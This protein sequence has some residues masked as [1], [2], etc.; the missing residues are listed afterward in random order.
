ESGAESA[1]GN[2][3]P[4]N[5]NPTRC[6]GATA[7]REQIR[8]RNKAFS[9]GAHNMINTVY[10]RLIE[11]GADSFVRLFPLVFI[12]VHSW[13]FRIVTAKAG[14]CS[15]HRGGTWSQHKGRRWRRLPWR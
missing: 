13:L 12:R 7:R 14:D 2:P 15:R 8:M 10:A 6:D 1:G 5:R 3:R 9:K 11:G 4:E